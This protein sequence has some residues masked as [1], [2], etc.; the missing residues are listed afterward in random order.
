[1]N[2][3]KTMN[4]KRKKQPEF[5]IQKAVCRYLSIAYPEVLFLSDTVASVRLTIM[6]GTRNKLIQKNGFKCPDLLIFEPKGP[7]KGLFIELK[8]ETPFKKDGTLKKNEHLEGQQKSINDLKAKG[9][10]A[11]F[12]VGLAETRLIIDEYMSL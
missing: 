5:E 11:T 3:T 7:Y 6:Q 9:Y 2:Y 8:Y 12:S 1:M 4:R 10:Y